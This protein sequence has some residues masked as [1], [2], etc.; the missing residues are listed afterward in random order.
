MELLLTWPVNAPKANCQNGEALIQAAECSHLTV[1]QMLLDSNHAPLPCCQKSKAI[2]ES[3]SGSYGCACD[4]HNCKPCVEQNKVLHILVNHPKKYSKEKDPQ[5][6]ADRDLVRAAKRK[7]Y[8]GRLTLVRMMVESSVFPPSEQAKS[9]ALES[10][11]GKRENFDV[12]RHLTRS[13]IKNA[14]RPKGWMLTR[15]VMNGDAQLLRL[16]MT[17][18]H[19]LRGDADDSEALVWAVR[20]GQYE[21]VAMLLECGARPDDQFGLPLQVAEE[22]GEPEIAALLKSYL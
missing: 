5:T 15:A 8:E 18:K 10:V 6:A 9:L 2:F 3:K 16:L 22:Y 4:N 20:E 11:F 17:C 7:K 12:V 14:A 1:V 19:P 13:D 21:T